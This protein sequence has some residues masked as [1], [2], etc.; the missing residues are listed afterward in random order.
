MRNRN[1]R[2]GDRWD[3]RSRSGDFYDRERG[4]SPEDGPYRP[5]EEYFG[6][7]EQYGRGIGSSGSSPEYRATSW[8]TSRSY[9][10]DYDREDRARSGRYGE[11]RGRY[12]EG[13]SDKP[14]S[15]VGRSNF[16]TGF[17]GWGSNK[18]DRNSYDPYWTSDEE[19]E[20]ERGRHGTHH[21]RWWDKAA[22]EVASWFGDDEAERRRQMDYRREG[23]FRGRGP[24]GY[25]RSDD[26]IR[27]DVNDRLTDDYALDASD[28]EIEVNNGDIVLSG[29]VDSRFEKRRAEDV[30]ESV[31]GVKNVE[32]RL[33]VKD[34]RNSDWDSSGEYPNDQ[35]DT[36]YIPS[37]TGDR[38]RG[39]GGTT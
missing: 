12:N 23:D 19:N 3:D 6:Q 14:D 24:K 11:H 30:A 8:R 7:R 25:T 20:R 9:G 4:L 18:Y 5:D 33:R 21:R 13:Y 22:D 15:W 39:V 2:R 17:S 29:T 28:I 10:R 31:S 27:D 36:R 32:N 38:S 16:E 34:Y 1:P 35:T 26:R 37:E